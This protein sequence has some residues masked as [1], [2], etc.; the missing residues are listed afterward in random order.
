MREQ[1]L[2]QGGGAEDCQIYGDRVLNGKSVLPFLSLQAPST[3]PAEGTPWPEQ[4]TYVRAKAEAVAIQANG[5]IIRAEARVLHRLCFL[6]RERK[7]NAQGWGVPCGRRY[8]SWLTESEQGG[9]DRQRRRRWFGS[10]T[11][12]TVNY[13]V[14]SSCG[15]TLVIVIAN[16]AAP[17]AAYDNADDGGVAASLLLLVS[18]PA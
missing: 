13:A 18:C 12:V 6:M 10:T 11:A 4:S 15:P 16:A 5:S 1:P 17:A 14:I 3:H 8:V 9:G 2:Q 7:E